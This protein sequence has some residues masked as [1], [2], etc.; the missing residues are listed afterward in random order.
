MQTAILKKEI[1]GMDSRKVTL[2]MR[3]VCVGWLLA[4]FIGW[5]LWIKDR[6]F[7]VVPVFDWLDWPS[8]VQYILFVLSLGFIALL[9]FKP[10]NKNLLIGLFIT[11]CISCAGDQNRW[12][13]WEYQYLF[14][15]VICIINFKD[16]KKIITG[17]AFMMAAIYVYS[18]TGKFNEGYLVLVWDNIFL[19]KIFNIDEAL[20]QHNSIHY[21]GYATA[22][23]EILFAAGL[24]FEKTKKLSA[25]GMIAMHLLILYAIGPLGID[26][27]T[28]VWPWNILM[29]ILLYLLFIKK[30]SLQ[31]NIPL[32]WQGWNKIVLIAWGI[33][34]ALNYVGLW[35][36]YLSSRLYSGGLPLMAICI[37]DAGEMDELQPYFSRTDMYNLCNG[38]AMVNLQNWCMKELNVPPYPEMRVYKKIEQHWPDHHPNS[39]TSFVYYYILR[40]KQIQKLENK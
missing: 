22:A 13:P 9:I 6:Q 28:I 20:I 12:Q 25:I 24:F 29:I 18:G 31:I 16:H 5:K 4:K 32:S 2:V 17:I 27:N 3:L 7:P 37:K 11:E 33:L 19:K 1:T 10:L 26:Y 38:Q 39:T 23:A 15:I 40:Q 36:N 8:I 21:W 30:Q 34:P 35:D 14:T